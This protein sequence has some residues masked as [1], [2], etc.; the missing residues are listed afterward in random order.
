MAGDFTEKTKNDFW[1]PPEYR[2]ANKSS[3][4]TQKKSHEKIFDTENYPSYAGVLILC[5]D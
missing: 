5:G 3:S 1:T 4:T 2:T